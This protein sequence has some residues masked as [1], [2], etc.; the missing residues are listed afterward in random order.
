[1]LGRETLLEQTRRR[2]ALAIPPAR[3]LVALTRSH[4]RY[5]APILASAPPHCTLV[6]PEDRGTAAPILYGALRI[7]AV[8]PMGALAVLPSDHWVSDDSAFMAHVG[9]AFSALRLRPDLVVLLGFVPETA[10]YGWIEPADRIPGTALL[11]VAGF[12]EKPA[13]GLAQA[14][15][16]RGCLWNSSVMIARIPALL[17]LF[18]SAV[19]ELARA[20]AAIEPMLGTIAEP[21]AVRSLY[22]TLGAMSFS[23]EVLAR[24]PANLAVLPVEGVR[25]SDWGRPQRVIDTLGRL[26]TEP[27][28][29]GRAAALTA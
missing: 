6:Q 3:V 13:L 22:R 19:P 26:G 16:G 11:R 17:A 14:L 23:D 9:A 21:R 15:P 2:A 27:A 8:E 4:E 7:A 5:Y 20:F 12:W 1:M 28:W 18:R 24:R 25:W 10:E 29:P